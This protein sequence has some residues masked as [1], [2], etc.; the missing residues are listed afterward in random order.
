MVQWLSPPANAGR[1]GSIPG[2]GTKIPHAKGQ[3]SPPH[4]PQLEKPVYQNEETVHHNKEPAQPKDKTEICGS[5]NGYIVYFKE[6]QC[7]QMNGLKKCGGY[8]HGHELGQTPGD[9][10]EQGG[11]VCCNPWG[12]KES[13]ITWQVN[14]NN[15]NR[16][17]Q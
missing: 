16:Y 11:L 3:L 2:Q 14:N 8:I 12:C 1:V 13:D 6:R 17:I 7:Q 4:V 15:N 9:S 10:E 5:S